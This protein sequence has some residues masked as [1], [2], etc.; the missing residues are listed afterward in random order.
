ME[1]TNTFLQLFSFRRSRMLGNLYKNCTSGSDF[2][3]DNSP[4]T[5]KTNGR[6]MVKNKYYKMYYYGCQ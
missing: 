2:L 4:M 6:K 5:M 3:I 1:I